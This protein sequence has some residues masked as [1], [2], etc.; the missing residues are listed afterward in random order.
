MSQSVITN[1]F[2]PW[3]A[4]RLAENKPAR[5]DRMVF[6]W[7]EGQDENAEINP[8]EQLPAKSLIT[9]TADIVHFGTL[10]ERAFVCSVVLDTTVGN[11]RYNWIGLVDSESD[12]LLMIVHT[13]EQQKI[14]TAAGIQGN[15]LSRNLMMEFSGAAAAS[16]ITVTAETWQID[17][18]ARLRSMDEAGRLALVDYYGQAAF[19]G[20]G[21]LVTVQ[22][23]VAVVEPGLGYVS[24]L[25]VEL[26]ESRSFAVANGSGVWVDAVWSGTV[27]GA[28]VHSFKVVAAV[29]LS[30]YI[31]SAG[32]QH[33]VTRIASVTASGV[34]DLR[35]PFPLQKLEQ[36]VDE[37][38]VYSKTEAD[39]RFLQAENNLSD[40]TDA[41]KARKSLDVHSKT[42][43]DERFLQAENN[44]SDVADAEEARNNL[45]LA[46]IEGAG[47]RAIIDAVFWVGRT[48][49]SDSNP[50][51]RYS[52]QTWKDLSADYNGRVL[53]VSTEAWATGG[54]NKVKIEADNLP[55]HWH[56]SGDR[57]PGATWDPTTTHGTDNQKSGPLALTEGTYVDAAGQTES[58]NKEV[59][60]TNE[61]VTVRAWRRTA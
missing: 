4:A 17:Y 29:N 20:N 9:H 42:E 12:T 13:A 19:R 58:T 10:N 31:D 7:I 35:T 53:R 44:L 2:S 61:Y 3:L 16:Q 40:V 33:Y 48:V 21:F 14:K 38:D 47:F 46:D 34:K 32:F 1:A 41:G 43:A 26:S 30:D 52:W 23:N 11:W 37:L 22:D 59:D 50:Q 5:P 25:R 39:E 6:A 51:S 28:W 49:I 60:V 56:R 36:T 55:P 18:S 8:D 45:G 24:G 15:T 27:T 54:K 57:S